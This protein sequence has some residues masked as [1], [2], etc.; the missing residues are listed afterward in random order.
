MKTFA[1]ILISLFSLQIYAGSM[2]YEIKANQTL[3]LDLEEFDNYS[4]KIKNNSNQE[5]DVSVH[6]SESGKKAKG[7]GLPGGNSAKL[8]VEEGRV[9][10]LKN[11]SSETV[12]VTLSFVDKPKPKMDDRSVYIRFTLRNGSGESIPLIIPNVM[13]PN[14]SPYSNSGVSLKIGQEIL[15]RYKGKRRVLFV[16]DESIKEGDKI[17]VS[18]IYKRRMKEI[19]EQ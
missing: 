8:I 17:E 3:E 13:N 15:F 4:V 12:K 1:A 9:L 16:V 11:S 2:S 19:D 14:L 7:F 5:I 10:R 18:E 6:E